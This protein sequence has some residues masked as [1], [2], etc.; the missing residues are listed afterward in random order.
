[1]GQA[2][3]YLNWAHPSTTTRM[4]FYFPEV[5]FPDPESL[6]MHLVQIQISAEGVLH[7]TLTEESRVFSG[8]ESDLISKRLSNYLELS[9]QQ[10]NLFFSRLEDFQL[11]DLSVAAV[12]PAFSASLLSMETFSRTHSYCTSARAHPPKASSHLCF[13]FQ[14]NLS[15]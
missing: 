8:L 2:Q 7:T 5:P 14:Y 12:R 11:A 3:A 15:T 10:S 6:L 13:Y 4:S 1:M 9:S